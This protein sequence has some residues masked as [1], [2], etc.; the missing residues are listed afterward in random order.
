MGKK[1]FDFH[2]LLYTSAFL[3]PRTISFYR[4]GEH[5]SLQRSILPSDRVN[6]LE[7]ELNRKYHS[8]PTR[9]LS[10]EEWGVGEV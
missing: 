6:P 10:N 1:D 7:Y 5:I 3:F 8:L 2:C 4:I 9:R